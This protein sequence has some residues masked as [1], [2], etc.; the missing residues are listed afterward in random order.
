MEERLS[1]LEQAPKHDDAVKGSRNSKSILLFCVIL[2]LLV[3]VCSVVIIV[4]S[5]NNSGEPDVE[6]DEQ[7]NSVDAEKISQLIQEAKRL[8]QECDY[9]C[10]DQI[11]ENVNQIMEMED[12]YESV[13]AVCRYGVK[14][15]VEDVYA[16]YCTKA[17]AMKQDQNGSNSSYGRLVWRSEDEE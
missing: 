5:S 1:N 16:D 9:D 4:L 2:G 15:S 3:V 10:S 17:R 13:F 14:Y 7:S 12:T 8:D 11:L 6:T